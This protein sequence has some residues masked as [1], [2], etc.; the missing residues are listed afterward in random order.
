M[1]GTDTTVSGYVTSAVSGAFASGIG[2]TLLNRGGQSAMLERY[3]ISQSQNHMIRQ[4]T[5]RI[6]N[7]ELV[8]VSG[9]KATQEVIS[10]TNIPKSFVLE[11]VTIN[12]KE[13]WVHA[14]ATKHM[15]EFVNSARG[16]VLVERNDVKLSKCSKSAFEAPT[17]RWVEI[18]FM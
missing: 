2:H 1:A 4:D 14:N 17:S 16:S 6:T 5:I 10:G 13:V 3:A 15:G 11:G 9:I 7:H 18:L 8:R 12:G